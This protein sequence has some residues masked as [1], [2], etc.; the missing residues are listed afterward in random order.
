MT[1][2]VYTKNELVPIFTIFTFFALCAICSETKVKK[3]EK[4]SITAE[5]SF[6][7]TKASFE[8]F[9]CNVKLKKNL[10]SLFLVM[11]HSQ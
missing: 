8:R 10:K 11:N 5:R 7:I 3:N 1:I 9:I 6:F 2:A 4:K